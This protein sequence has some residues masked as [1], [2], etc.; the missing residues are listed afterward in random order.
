[1]LGQEVDGRRGGGGRG[2]KERKVQQV[3][4]ICIHIAY[5]LCCIAET[6][7]IVKQQYPN[8]FLKRV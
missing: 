3:R 6:H 7:N 1:M 5:S 2:C 4:V 8:F